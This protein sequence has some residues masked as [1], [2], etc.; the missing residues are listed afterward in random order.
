MK[1]VFFFLLILFLFEAAP[2][3]AHGLVQALNSQ[4]TP[5]SVQDAEDRIQFSHMQEECPI[6]W[7]TTLA[8]H[9]CAL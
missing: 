8:P 6:H 3:S 5:G 9:Y 4:M 1:Q 7:V 2:S